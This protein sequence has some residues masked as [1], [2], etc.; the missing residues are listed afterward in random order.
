[1]YD[2]APGTN[3]FNITSGSNH[4][5]CIG[6]S[7]DPDGTVNLIVSFACTN[8]YTAVGD[9]T[10]NLTQNSGLRD[11]AGNEVAT[12][13][14]DSGSSPIIADGASP[15]VVNTEPADNSTGINRGQDI[16][17]D[18]S[19][20]MNTGSF[21][22]SD[23]DTNDYTGTTWLVSDSQATS[24]HNTWHASRLINMTIDA[25]DLVGRWLYGGGGYNWS[26]RTR[27]SGGGGVYIPPSESS[28]KINNDAAQ[29]T[30]RQVTLTLSAS[31]AAE[32]II[33]ENSNLLGASWETY[34]TTKSTVSDSI[35]YVESIEPEPEPELE[36]EF[37]PELEPEPEF[38]L[39]P[40]PVPPIPS[41]EFPQGLKVG[42]LIKSSDNSAVYYLGKDGRKHVFPNAT[43]FLSWYKDFSDIKIVTNSVLGSIQTGANV[44]IRP[45]SHLI[46]IPSL[47]KVYAVEPGGVIRWITTQELAIELY[48]DMWN[49]LTL[50]LFDSFVPDYIEG[51]DIVEAEHSTGTLLQYFNQLE[52]Y[53]IENGMKR[54][55]T[56]KMNTENQF[57]D[58]FYIKGIS[59]DIS[60]PAGESLP[61]MDYAD[62][63][64]Q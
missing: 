30:S 47:S 46:K 8:Y 62:I 57:Q 49:D 61:Y 37:E 31:D 24:T 14:L 22:I 54:H 7:A 15:V 43:V 3:G 1:L 40:E 25:Q 6:E 56:P 28:I 20:P 42:D 64:F 10:L 18:F 50:D 51:A 58:R 4:G 23:D 59:P 32:M 19:E 63:M 45:G 11:A 36:P 5:A 27:S 34:A 39:E 35:D 53:F 13:V 55:I 2:T 9:I 12:V 41:V 52:V 16:I 44:T 60:Y 17:I 38:E 29:T 26:F 21:T 48:G 33:S